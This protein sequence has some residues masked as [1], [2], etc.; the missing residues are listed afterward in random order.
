MS[1]STSLTGP[2]LR[3]YEAIFRHPLPHNLAWRDVRALLGHL[4]QVTEEPNGH[5]K[6]TRNGHTLI[7]QPTHAKEVAE[8]SMLQELRRF[9][10]R[11]ETP[12]SPSVGSN[13]HWLVVI[14]HH[15]ARIYSSIVQDDVELRI[16]PPAPE[17]HFRHSHHARDFSRGQEKPD[18]ATF[19]APVAAVLGAEGKILV[20][21]SGKGKGSEMEQFIAWAKRHHPALAARIIGSVVVDDHHTTSAQLLAKARKFYATVAPSLLR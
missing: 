3:T 19:F 5:L 20:F 13:N 15:E 1:S 14:D 9:F 12:A 6:V 16:L 8:F 17:A 2:H 21:G 10:E 11:S 7:L 4:G 18:P